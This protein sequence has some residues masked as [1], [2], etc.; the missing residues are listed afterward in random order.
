MCKLG[1]A[2]IAKTRHEEYARHLNG[3]D[4][5]FQFLYASPLPA[6]VV[7]MAVTTLP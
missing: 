4:V 6:E 5:K 3:P 1:L 7:L 2:S